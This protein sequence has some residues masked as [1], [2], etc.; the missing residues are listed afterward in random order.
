MLCL[1]HYGPAL[2]RFWFQT[3]LGCENSGGHLEIPVGRTFSCQGH[4]LVTLYVQFL[5]SVWSKCD[6]WLHVENLC[7]ILNLV[8]FDS[9]SLQSFC[10]FPLD[11]QKWNTAAITVACQSRKS[12]L[13]WHCFRFSPRLKSLK[14]YC[15]LRQDN[16]W[17]YHWVN[18]ILACRTFEQST[19]IKVVCMDFSDP[20]GDKAVVDRLAATCKNHIWTYINA[21][22]NVTTTAEMKEA[23][24]SYGGVEGV[25]VAI[26][27]SIE[28]T[29]ELQKISGTSKIN[30]FLFTEDSLQAWRTYAIGPGKTIASEKVP[31]RCHYWEVNNKKGECL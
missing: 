13:G 16:T 20:Q 10:L 30:N 28:E 17:C 27:L 29:V 3:N 25:W 4:A 14:Q 21:G 26:L 22:N 18:T 8:Y 19:G 2:L 31:G 15:H 1:C 6:R 24:L 7:S 12:D 9:W 11:V 23:L 5:C